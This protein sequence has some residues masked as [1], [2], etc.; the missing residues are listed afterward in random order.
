[1][2]VY[3]SAGRRRRSTA[4]VAVG[5]L[6]LGLLV[7]VL[8]GRGSAPTVR[9]RIRSV[10]TD[11]RATAAGLRVIAIHDEAGGTAG[12]AGAATGGGTD[13]VLARTESELR[14]EFKAAPWLTVAAKNAL[15]DRLS[16][17]QA[18]TDKTAPAFGRAAEALAREIETTFDA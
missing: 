1:M 3:M 10:Q 4:L 13:L 8:L 17:L 7:G 14:T 5:G 6:V 2:A 9:D 18:T 15:L 16:K 11:A 12:T